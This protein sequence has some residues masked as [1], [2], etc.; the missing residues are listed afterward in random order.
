MTQALRRIDHGGPADPDRV[1]G[2]A[3]TG[4]EFSFCFAEGKTFLE[5]ATMP[6]LERGFQSAA[7]RVV[8]TI[9]EP[10][11]Y[12]LPALAEE[13]GRVFRLQRS[14]HSEGRRS[15]RDGTDDIR[16]A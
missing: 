10:L 6:L 7:F 15:H 4:E 11:V 5:A 2:I 9:W 13:T 12:A 1:E 8:D 16:E 3:G 14:D